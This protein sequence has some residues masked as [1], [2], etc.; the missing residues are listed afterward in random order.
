LSPSYFT[1]GALLH[2]SPWPNRV[3]PRDPFVRAFAL[4]TGIGVLGLTGLLLGLPLE[5][6]AIR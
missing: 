3:D 4:L 5:R 1:G 6:T 2:G